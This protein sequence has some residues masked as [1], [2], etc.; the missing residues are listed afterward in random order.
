MIKADHRSRLDTLSVPAPFEA[1]PGGRTSAAAVAEAAAAAI[2]DVTR[3]LCLRRHAA[4]LRGLVIT[5]SLARSEAT[6]RQGE[7]DAVSLLGD[8]EFL[9]LCGAAGAPSVAEMDALR[10][11]IE[12]SLFTR[13]V[14]GH[15]GIAAVPVGYLG[16]LEPSIFAYE[17]KTCGRVLAGDPRILDR[18]PAFASSE[19]PLEDAWSML[20]NRLVEQL[21]FAREIGAPGRTLTRALHYRTVKLFLDMATSLLVFL[22][23]YEPT[24][25]ARAQRLQALARDTEGGLMPFPLRPFAEEVSTCTRWKLSPPPP[26]ADEPGADRAL[27]ERALTY[28]RLLARWE[29]TQ[30][31]NLGCA[32]PDRVLVQEWRR[33]QPLRGRLRGWVR[34]VRDEGWQR[35]WREWPRWT[36]L[37]RRGSPRRWLYAA[38]IELLFRLPSLVDPAGASAGSATD[39]ESLRQQLPVPGGQPRAAATSSCSWVQLAA[40]IVANYRRFLVPTRS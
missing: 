34:V 5:G 7:G 24:Y 25:R 22:R 17:L 31:T 15:I 26:G 13:G 14:T 39:V 16:R 12:E 21:E 40:D 20:C 29:L 35:S 37:A 11:A 28:A 27:L 36:R 2:C 33:R 10:N 18:V 38:T 9:L 30:L 23:A 3:R 32:V 1:G 4:R 19:I 8:A 6:F